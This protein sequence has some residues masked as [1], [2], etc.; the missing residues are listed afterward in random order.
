MR[1]LAWRRERTSTWSWSR[2]VLWPITR[3]NCCCRLG[4]SLATLARL[5]NGSSQTRASV[6]ATASQRWRPLPSASSP[7]SSPGRWKPSTCSSPASLTPTVLKAPS[8]ATYTEPKGSPAR[9]SD[10]P[11]FSGLRRCTTASSRPRSWPSTP[12]GRHSRCNEHSAQLRRRRARSRGIA[13]L[14][15]DMAAIIGDP[16]GGCPRGQVKA[17]DLIQV[18]LVRRA[19]SSISADFRRH[20]CRLSAKPTTT[21]W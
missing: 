7:N 15:A 6:R 12:A 1:S 2:S 9:N 13:A 11:G 20:A 17:R 21:R 5:A 3:S 8:L 19:T 18:K 14:S 10:S 16:R 4:N